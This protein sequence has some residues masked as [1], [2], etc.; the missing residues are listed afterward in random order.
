MDR[1]VLGPRWPFIQF[2]KLRLSGEIPRVSM[3]V[4]RPSVGLYM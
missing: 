1:D 2:Q 3:T 4:S